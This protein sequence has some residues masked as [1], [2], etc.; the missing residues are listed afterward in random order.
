M[1]EEAG[2][3]LQKHKINE[4]KNRKSEQ[5]ADNVQD[6]TC[7]EQGLRAKNQLWTQTNISQSKSI[8][9]KIL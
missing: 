8:I 6:A 7:F 1:F 5:C 4:N 2:R 3:I 9:F